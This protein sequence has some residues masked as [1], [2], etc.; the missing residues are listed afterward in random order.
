MYIS[1][2]NEII[3]N[4]I[5]L[6]NHEI[7]S[8]LNS[9]TEGMNRHRTIFVMGNGGSAATSIHFAED[10]N[11]SA[12]LR[13]RA[14]VENISDVTALANDCGYETIFLNQLKNHAIKGDILFAISCSGNSINVIK[15]VEW[16]RENGIRTI[17][18]TGFDGGKLSQIDEIDI[19]VPSNNIRICED[20]HMII[21]HMIVQKLSEKRNG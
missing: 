1:Y 20:V 2:L 9:I 10:L 21:C 15:A 11:K 8:K 4:L 6:K 12:N 5:L 19:N 18:L 7:V 3:S 17:G 14:L 16:A 13:A